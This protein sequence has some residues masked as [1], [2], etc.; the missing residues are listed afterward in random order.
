MLIKLSGAG[1]IAIEWTLIGIAFMLGLARLD[2]RFHHHQSG[3]FLRDI[4]YF[5]ALTV[6]LVNTS[7]DTALW[8]SG[9]ELY[10][11]TN[12]TWAGPEDVM[13]R[14]LKVV[15]VS[16]LTF[17]LQLYLTKATLLTLYFE[18]FGQRSR[19]T[20]ISLYALTGFC[21]SGFIITIF[22]LLFGDPFGSTWSMDAS[23]RDEDR[24][25]KKDVVAW[26]FHFVTDLGIFILPI[27]CISRLQMSRAQKIS[28]GLTFGLGFINI[29]ITIIRW[30]IVHSP[31]SPPSTYAVD[32]ALFMTDA[33]TCLIIS[34]LPSLRLYLRI[35]R[36]E[37]TT[38]RA[39]GTESRSHA[40]KEPST[41]Q[42]TSHPH[43]NG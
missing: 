36:A 22:L 29:S 18:I 41:Y 38:S 34:I 6:G 8:T 5:S 39:K 11:E 7:L 27:V 32:Q 28:A 16:Y 4:F 10:E 43:T 26:A 2:L 20:L 40:R 31:V 14:A 21:I 9:I 37:K 25:F 30:F 24:Q 35:F 1:L 42:E 13:V 33:H 17:Y 15:F 23:Q 19:K 12:D 3:F